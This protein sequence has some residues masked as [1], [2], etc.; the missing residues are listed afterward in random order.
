M[1]PKVVRLIQHGEWTTAVELIGGPYAY[2]VTTE[3]GRYS[4]QPQ[5]FAH[6]YEEAT[7][8]VADHMKEVSAFN[9]EN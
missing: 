3:S 2:R 7:R 6:T 4:L 1:K 5:T 9:L 8:A